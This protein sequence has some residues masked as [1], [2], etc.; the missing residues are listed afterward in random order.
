LRESKLSGE[1]RSL[2][3]EVDILTCFIATFLFGGGVL[4]VCENLSDS[5]FLLTWWLRVPGKSSVDVEERDNLE[6]SS[7]FFL[8]DNQQ[9]CKTVFL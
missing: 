4:F 8:S 1:Q 6:V 7:S 2:G 3:F 5:A 9:F